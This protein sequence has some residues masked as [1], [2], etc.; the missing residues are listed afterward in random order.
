MA[1]A[2]V[3]QKLKRG[4]RKMQFLQDSF[5]AAHP[6]AGIRIDPDDIAD[7][8]IKEKLWHPI[9]ATQQQQLARLIRRSLRDTYI[10][11][12]QGREVRANL[13][14]MEDKLTS[15]GLKR[16]TTWYPIFEAPA[17]VARTSFALRRRAAFRDCLQLHFD[18][19]SW[20]ENN[21]SGHELDGMDYDFNADIE[22]VS[23]P[24]TYS[25]ELLEDPFADDDD[26]EE[27]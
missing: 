7:W 20:N 9:P 4:S 8:A 6:E 24:T 18:F 13:P 15:E 14:I 3:P 16:K 19:L 5:R 11:D 21:A 23:M 12:P 22:D 1:V 10:T 25:D 26:N 27:S 17:D 2:E